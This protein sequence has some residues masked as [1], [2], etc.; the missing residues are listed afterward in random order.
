[1]TRCRGG[2][3]PVGHVAVQLIALDSDPSSLTQL[4]DRETATDDGV[5][6]LAVLAVAVIGPIAGSL[7]PRP[8][9]PA[10]AAARAALVSAIEV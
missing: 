6:L 3:M 2:T 5:M 8:Y 9:A 1:M 4:H 7:G 10:C